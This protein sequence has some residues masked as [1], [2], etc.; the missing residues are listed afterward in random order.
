MYCK[1]G[2]HKFKTPYYWLT[3]NSDCSYYYNFSDCYINTNNT[4]YNF[5]FIEECLYS[6]YIVHNEICKINIK[7]DNLSEEEVIEMCMKFIDNLCFV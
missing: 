2:K 7:N 1:C 3:N 4:I 5:D 6:F